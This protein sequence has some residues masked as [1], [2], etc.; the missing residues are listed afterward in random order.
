M[1]LFTL[2]S[3]EGMRGRWT[4]A[5]TAGRAHKHLFSQWVADLTWH[6]DMA[7]GASDWLPRSAQGHQ[8]CCLRWVFLHFLVPWWQ[9]F[10]PSSSSLSSSSHFP[11]PFSFP[12]DNCVL[13]Q[14]RGT[15]SPACFCLPVRLWPIRQQVILVAW[16]LGVSL[17]GGV[18]SS[19]SATWTLGVVL[20]G[21]ADV[22]HLWAEYRRKQDLGETTE[23][24]ERCAGGQRR[25]RRVRIWTLWW[26]C[27]A[28]IG[29][30]RTQSKGLLWV[31]KFYKWQQH[32]C[33]C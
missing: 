29:Y 24:T 2:W 27:R 19:L 5:C 32:E 7:L 26:W 23:G 6:C 9:C 20:G 21:D 22:Y 17:Y 1:F 11:R 31:W 33:T 14:H 12:T 4:D 28:S 16:R 25:G 3:D 10:H 15:Y 30:Y 8:C 18:S 13:Q